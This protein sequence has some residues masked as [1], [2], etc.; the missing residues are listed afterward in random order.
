MEKEPPGK[1]NA[2]TLQQ[3]QNARPSRKARHT[4]LSSCIF[5]QQKRLPR[6]MHQNEIKTAARMCCSNE[7]KDPKQTHNERGQVTTQRRTL[8]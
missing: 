3:A 6:T 8:N 2:N 1:L 4:K 7:K 5:E